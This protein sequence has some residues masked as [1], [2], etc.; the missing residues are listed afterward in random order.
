[1][2]CPP[3]FDRPN[4]G[5]G[6]QSAARSLIVYNISTMNVSRSP[7]C[8]SVETSH[9]FASC[10]HIYVQPPT[11]SVCAQVKAAQA[12]QPKE[13]FI[14]S[15]GR[16]TSEHFSRSLLVPGPANAAPRMSNAEWRLTS[17]V[18]VLTIVVMTRQ[19]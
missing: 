19:S 16:T 6:P 12:Q 14:G 10:R 11:A 5:R 4:R 17:G 18:L 7:L 2:Q 9:P 8:T 13:V 3:Q 15:A 1:M